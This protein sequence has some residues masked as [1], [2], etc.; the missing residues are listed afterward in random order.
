MIDRRHVLSFD[1]TLFFSALALMCIG[2]A[3]IHSAT[4]HEVRDGLSPYTIRQIQWCSVAIL[5]VLVTLAVD[6][7]F[8]VRCGS[9]FYVLSVLVLLLVIAVGSEIKGAKSWIRLGP[10]NW[11]PSEQVKIFLCLALARHFSQRREWVDS[12]GL[13]DLILPGVL[14]AVPVG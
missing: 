9:A 13:K 4:H 3:C 14:F 2:I 12:L 10:M 11:Q 8:L 7:R 5:V 6:Y 1:F